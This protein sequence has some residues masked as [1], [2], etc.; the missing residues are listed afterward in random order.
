MSRFPLVLL[1]C[2]AALALPSQ[3]AHA[4]ERRCTGS[5]GAVTLDNIV[6]PDGRSCILNGTRAKGT[7]KVGRGASLAAH[8]VQINGNIQGEGAYSVVVR[9]NS[10]VG[11]SIQLKQGGAARVEYTR[12]NGDLLYDTNQRAL[13]ASYNTIGGNLQAFQ[14]RGGVSLVRNRIDGNLQCKENRPAPTGGGNQA[15]SKEDQCARL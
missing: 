1:A 10:F 5:I 15:S 7:L 12:I 9:R 13:A 11:G 2:A 4:E 6:V 8:G 14:N 3:S